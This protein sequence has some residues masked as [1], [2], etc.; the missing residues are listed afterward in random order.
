MDPDRET[1]GD[2]LPPAELERQRG[3]LFAAVRRLLAEGSYL[4]LPRRQILEC[5]R[6]QNYGGLTVEANLDDYLDLAVFYRGAE[7]HEQHRA[8]PAWRGPAKTCTIFRRAAVLVRS[9]EH[10]EHV[11]LKL[12]KNIVAEDLEM[13]LP[14]VRVRMRWLDGLKIGS[15]LAASLGMAA[16]KVLTTATAIL[17]S[18]VVFLLTLAALLTAM[19]RAVFAYLSNQTRY[20]QALSANLYFQNLANNAGVLSYLVDSAEAEETKEL[21]LA[22]FLLHVERAQDYTPEALGRRVRQWV[23]AQ[24]NLAI[25]FDVR[26]TVGTLVERGLAAL[27][28]PGPL[29]GRPGAQASAGSG[30]APQPPAPIVKAY[31][32]PA[33]LQRLEHS[34]GC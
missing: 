19:I 8:W 23:Q 33:A 32:P 12:F 21:L 11:H 20:M 15:G 3:E 4:E 1:P 7:R 13:V 17:L 5:V 9:A 34:G 27:G 25:D 10:P 31:D 28:A 2:G 22:Y 6:L 30:D 29:G 14:R 18:P 26:Q 24:F 16:W